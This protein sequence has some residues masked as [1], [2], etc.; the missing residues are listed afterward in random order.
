MKTTS[1]TAPFAHQTR[2]PGVDNLEETRHAGRRR[3]RPETPSANPCGLGLRPRQPFPPLFGN[4]GGIYLQW[5]QN[6]KQ[7]IVNYLS[8][9]ALIFRCGAWKNLRSLV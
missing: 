4:L 2:L 5:R 9:Q 6:V 7:M 1:W 3:L 8:P